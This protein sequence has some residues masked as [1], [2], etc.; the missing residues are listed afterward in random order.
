MSAS[1]SAKSA[2]AKIKMRK[3]HLLFSAYAFAAAALFNKQ[4]QLHKNSMSSELR[5]NCCNYF[6]HKEHTNHILPQCVSSSTSQLYEFHA[7]TPDFYS[8]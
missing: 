3:S 6:P 2:T 5:Q 7:F 8:W 1:E 4:Q